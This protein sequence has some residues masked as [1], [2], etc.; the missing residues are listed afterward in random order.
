MKQRYEKK[1]KYGMI[2][3]TFKEQGIRWEF[4]R[5]T[6]SGFRGVWESIIPKYAT[7]VI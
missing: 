3:T 2:M 4:N 1:S 7:R 6:G 5:H